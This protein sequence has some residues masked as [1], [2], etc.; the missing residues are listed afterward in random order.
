MQLSV[1]NCDSFFAVSVAPNPGDSEI[2]EARGKRG[3]RHDASLI[4][5]FSTLHPSR[6]L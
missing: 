2:A 4:R 6:S 3:F 1:L 5:L